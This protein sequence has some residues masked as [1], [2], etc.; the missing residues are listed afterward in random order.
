MTNVTGTQNVS[1][2]QKTNFSQKISYMAAAD[3]NYDVSI[4]MNAMDNSSMKTTMED[5]LKENNGEM[6]SNLEC[7]SFME[8]L[9]GLVKGL[10]APE[11]NEQQT[12]ETPADADDKTAETEIDFSFTF[13]TQTS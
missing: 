10:F 1:N 8:K 7:Q 11:K 12:V 2:I 6:P 13:C 3:S 4:F 9:M 5:L